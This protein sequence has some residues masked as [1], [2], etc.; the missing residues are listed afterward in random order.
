MMRV[1]VTVGKSAIHGLGVFAIDPIRKGT[2]LW[3]YE[4]GFDHQVSEYSIKYGEKRI[5]DFVRERGY[6]NPDDPQVWVVCVDEAQFWNFPKRDEP[7]NTELGGL[8]DGEFLILAARDI[9]PNEEITIPPESDAD[10]E[11]KMK[12]R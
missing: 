2:V 11:R 4:P 6:I 8:V 10:Y 9:E 1:P 7:A 5:Q 3:Q 12:G